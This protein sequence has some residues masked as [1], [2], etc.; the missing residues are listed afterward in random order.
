MVDQAF[1]AQSPNWSR[2]PEAWIARA[3]L[4]KARAYQELDDPQAAIAGFDAVIERFA[5]R[6]IPGV[7]MQV[8]WALRDKGET[9]REQGELT[10]AMAAAVQGRPGYDE[11]ITGALAAG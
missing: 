8:A 1:T 2:V 9:Q 5:S 10:A 3:L 4:M 11:I 7:Q 6:D